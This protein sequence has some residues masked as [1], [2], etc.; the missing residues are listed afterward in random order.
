MDGYPTV[1]IIIVTAPPLPDKKQQALQSYVDEDKE[2]EDP[3]IIKVQEMSPDVYGT[4]SEGRRPSFLPEGPVEKFDV[5]RYPVPIPTYLKGEHAKLTY[6]TG[7]FLNILYSAAT[8][9]KLLFLELI[10]KK[11]GILRASTCQTNPNFSKYL[12]RQSMG[13]ALSALVMLRLCKSKHWIPKIV[14]NILKYGETLF[15]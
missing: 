3:N 1:N 2:P 14:D 11:M 8:I 10:P 6:Y 5:C 4:L 12:G 7:E 15:R 9:K 13:N